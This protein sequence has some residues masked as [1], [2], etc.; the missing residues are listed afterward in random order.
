[1]NNL[2]GLLQR[3]YRRIADLIT[4]VLTLESQR[5]LDA[6]MQDAYSKAMAGGATQEAL[7]Q[8]SAAMGERAHSFASRENA[9]R[10]RQWTEEILATEE[11]WAK[12][13]PPIFTLR[14]LMLG[15]ILGGLSVLFFQHLRSKD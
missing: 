11:A 12:E 9:K 6:T 5:R 1:V 7:N 10:I 15:I 2:E 4:P 8:A 13:H 14:W 3:R